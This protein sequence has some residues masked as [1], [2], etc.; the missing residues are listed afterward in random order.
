MRKERDL[1]EKAVG[2]ARAFD[3]GT[4]VIAY[5]AMAVSPAFIPA[6]MVAVEFSVVT[7]AG[8]EIADSEIKRRKNK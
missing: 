7:M 2:L 8:A 6:A 5:T 1:G 3:I 4:I